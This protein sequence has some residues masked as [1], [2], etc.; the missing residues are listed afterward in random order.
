MVLF[1]QSRSLFLIFQVILFLVISGFTNGGK[2]KDLE[3][4]VEEKPDICDYFAR[5]GDTVHVEYT[6]MLR[7]GRV[8]DTN[9][10]DGKSPL[11]FQLGAGTLIKGWE[12]GIQG[13][14]VGERRKLVIPPHLGYGSKGVNGVIPPESTL[15]F[16][17]HLLTLERQTISGQIT[18]FLQFAI[19]PIGIIILLHYLYCKITTAIE[20]ES[21][22]KPDKRLGK[23]RR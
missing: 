16:H 6:G 3:I 21:Q 7:D 22:R 2:R 10:K 11:K 20:E 1:A 17:V 14:C 12:R 23:K 8:F 9:M 4:I 19:W 18:K 5:V 15:L 13:M